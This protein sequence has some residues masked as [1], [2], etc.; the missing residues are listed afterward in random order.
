[1]NVGIGS[2]DEHETVIREIEFKLFLSDWIRPQVK[3]SNLMFNYF[4]EEMWF[5][6]EWLAR[7][8]SEENHREFSNSTEEE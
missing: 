8:I 2:D 7:C 5:L 1:V 6:E 3:H 4:D